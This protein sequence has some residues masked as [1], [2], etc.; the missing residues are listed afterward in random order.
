MAA[1]RRHREG[2][3]LIE[4]MIVIAI[5][6][7]AAAAVAPAL[8]SVTGANA[9]A[10]AGELA[11]S[12]RWLFDTAAMRH[13]TCRMALDLD[14]REW[15]AECVKPA[16]SSSA[17]AA[18]GAEDDEALADRFPDERSPEARRLL[19]RTSFGEY[20]DRQVRRRSLPGRTAFSEVRVEHLREPQSRGTAYVYFYPQGQAEQARVTVVDGDNAYSVLLQP[21]TGRARVV[22]GN[23]EVRR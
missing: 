17:A 13:T 6:A 21:L 7:T 9:R 1:G 12:M 8:S 18:P 20:V 3:T 2:F 14:K 23:P 19:A 22:P 15:W 11:G 16:A 5:V 4:L 10:A